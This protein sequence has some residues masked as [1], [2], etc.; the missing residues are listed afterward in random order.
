MCGNIK[1]VVIPYRIMK[2]KVIQTVQHFSHGMI[3][4]AIKENTSINEEQF[5]VI[6]KYCHGA[7]P[8]KILFWF[9]SE[10]ALSTS[11]IETL[12]LERKDIQSCH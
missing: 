6:Q 1:I 7:K 12:S 5:K 11:Y 8:F 10:A 4:G 2:I 3:R 9:M